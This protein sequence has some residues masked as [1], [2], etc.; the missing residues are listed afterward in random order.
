M[1]SLGTHSP[2]DKAFEEFNKV[3]N[4]NRLFKFDDK[5][6]SESDTRSKLIDPVFKDILGWHEA[7]IRREKPIDS[8]FIDYVLGSDYSYLLIEAKRSKPRFNLNDPGRHRRLKLDGPHLLGNK[9]IKPCVEQAQS[10]AADIGVQFCLVTNGS[11]IILFRPYV[12]GRPWRRDCNC[13]S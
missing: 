1:T 12:P 4:S 13:F 11:Q 9:K 2:A 10:Y 5:L 8:G 6:L 3:L 7:E